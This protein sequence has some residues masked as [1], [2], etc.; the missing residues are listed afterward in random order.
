MKRGLGGGGGA[1]E[2]KRC[3]VVWWLTLLD[4][5]ESFV[6]IALVA[7]KE[8]TALELL[9]VGAL[10]RFL[11]FVCYFGSEGDAAAKDCWCC[12]KLVSSFIII[13]LQLDERI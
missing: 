1:G 10:L 2:G 13:L 6:E 9:V 5:V 8:K 3:D 11:L 7:D 12:Y 4:E